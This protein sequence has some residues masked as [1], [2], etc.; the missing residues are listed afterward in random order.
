METTKPILRQSLEVCYSDGARETILVKRLTNTD[1]LKW[2]DLN[3]DKA[4]LMFRSVELSD[5]TRRPD[6]AWFDA[7]EQD[8]ALAVVEQAL[9]LNH[10]PTV[11]KKILG[12]VAAMLESFLAATPA[13]FSAA[14][15]PTPTSSPITN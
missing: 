2:L 3:F 8:S 5:Q 4:F 10:S 9:A 13:S 11:Q 14:A 6:Q 15:A 12:P 7:L 1:L